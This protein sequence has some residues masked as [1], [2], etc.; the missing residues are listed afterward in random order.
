MTIFGTGQLYKVSNTPP[1]L[2]IDTTIKSGKGFG[3]L[4]APTWDMVMNSK[5]G[6]ITWD[7]YTEQYYTLIRNRYNKNKSS[8]WRLFD[9][10]EE[11]VILC[12]YCPDTYH[13]TQHCHRYLAIDIL[14]KI[15]SK[16]NFEFS[17]EGEV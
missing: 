4:L 12:C 1:R 13:T 6:V 14:E 7:E 16:H 15:A 8:Y 9:F 17:Y 10:E 3:L 2:I 11:F 5:K